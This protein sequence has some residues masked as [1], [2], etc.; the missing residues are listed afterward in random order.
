VVIY[1]VMGWRPATNIAYSVDPNLSG[2][3]HL[4]WLKRRFLLKRSLE[5]QA[6]SDCHLSLNLKIGS[7]V[8]VTFN[9]DIVDGAPAA[10]FLKRFSELLM[11]GELLL[12]EADVA[13]E[14]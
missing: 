11:T 10:R 8:T 1:H 13:L 6:K 5:F 3:S 12:D 2:D 14:S 9:H 7:T 4:K